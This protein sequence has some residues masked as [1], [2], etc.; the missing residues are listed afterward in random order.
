[1]PIHVTVQM[2]LSHPNLLYLEALAIHSIILGQGDKYVQC[3]EE[4]YR[5]HHDKALPK[6]TEPGPA[7]HKIKEKYPHLT[8]A[9]LA[10]IQGVLVWRRPVPGTRHMYG[11]TALKQL[12]ARYNKSK[13]NS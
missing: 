10:L 13:E 6:V 11:A 12:I 4:L 9:E 1:M 2:F 7:I 5:Y 8:P 3:L